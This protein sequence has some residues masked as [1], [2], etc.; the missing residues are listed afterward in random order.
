VEEGGTQVNRYSRLAIDD[1]D[2]DVVLTEAIREG[3]D[4]VLRFNSTIYLDY[5]LLIE[6]GLA[7]CIPGARVLLSSMPGLEQLSFPKAVRFAHK[8][9][10]YRDEYDRIFGV[11][12]FF[13]SG[14]NAIVV[15]ARVLE[16]ELPKAN[17]YLANMLKER[18]DAL[19]QKMDDA[20]SVR[21]QVESLLTP[22]LH[23]RETK[24]D[25]I[26]KELAMSRQ[27]L[28]R[29]LK[30]EGVT[31]EQVLDDLRHK[32]AIRLL[33]EKLSVSETADRVG[34]S[35]PAAFSRAFR[36]WT[37]VSPREFCAQLPSSSPR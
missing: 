23:S 12:L 24:I 18:A 28:F 33:A 21:A 37:G 11:P 3:S 8:K 17:P 7:R 34:F 31:F 20:Q 10:S 5:P 22:L 13:E 35:E 36:R 25:A 14:M 9:P 19:L 29:R 2:D 4:V 16:L 26:A 1:G 6:S 32:M 27:T 30:S 15:D